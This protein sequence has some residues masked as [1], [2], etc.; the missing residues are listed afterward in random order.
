MTFDGRTAT[1]LVMLLLFVAACLLALDLPTKAAFM[2][3]LVG[4]PGALLCAAQ[5]VVD[6]RRP[7]DPKPEPSADPAAPSRSELEVFLW[8]G[9]FLVVLLT[10][11]FVVGGP[12]L[13]TAFIR[14]SSR[15]SWTTA[16][17]AGAG[18]LIVLW[19]VF[20]W[21][22]QLSLFEGLLLGPLLG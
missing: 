13:V 14:I 12:V 7:P 4:I 11:G 8:L 19:G 15:E 5:L 3:L 16:L 2:P 1:T 21:L 9:A 18:T 17:F 20:I 10:C 6:L 22:L